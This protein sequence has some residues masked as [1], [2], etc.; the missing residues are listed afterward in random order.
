MAYLEFINIALLLPTQ[1]AV[2]KGISPVS[3]GRMGKK[4]LKLYSG[5]AFSGR[6]ERTRICVFVEENY[7]YCALR[8]KDLK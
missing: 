6:P 7:C 4:D 3:L 8:M 2:K 1:C 5:I